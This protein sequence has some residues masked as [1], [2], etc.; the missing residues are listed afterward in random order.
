MHDP[1]LIPLSRNVTAFVDCRRVAV[2]CCWACV[3][4]AL[5][6]SRFGFADDQPMA[7]PQPTSTQIIIRNNVRDIT[8]K[9]GEETIRIQ[10][11][12]GNS[13]R[14]RHTYPEKD[15]TVTQTYEAENLEALEKKDAKGAELYRK[16]AQQAVPR[17]NPIFDQRLRQLAPGS[18]PVLIG[19]RRICGRVGGKVVQL[20][21]RHGRQ[22][23][24]RVRPQSPA[25]APVQEYSAENLAELRKSEPEI[26]KLVERLGGRR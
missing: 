15:K 16:Y 2:L 19:D 18:L 20:E 5:V 21:D 14:I 23:R 12:G 25:D 8:V 22:L 11:E 24:V 26:A 17:G 4:L 6:G 1:H 10:D 13:I 3:G 9:R 7:L